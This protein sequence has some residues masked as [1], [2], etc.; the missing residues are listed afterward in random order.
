MPKKNKHIEKRKLT[1]GEQLTEKVMKKLDLRDGDVIMHVNCREMIEYLGIL[2]TKIL[3]DPQ[4][5][6]EYVVAYEKVII[7]EVVK[8]EKDEY[9]NA[10]KE[11][12]TTT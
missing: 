10:F 7:E 2:K 5:A 11:G 12:M 3:I 4:D 1:E 9:E 8:G 6:Y